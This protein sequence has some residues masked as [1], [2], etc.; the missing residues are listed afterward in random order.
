M[1]NSSIDYILL[2]RVLL[3]GRYFR[4]RR[5]DIDCKILHVFWIFVFLL[6]TEGIFRRWLLPQYSNLFLVIRDPFVIY[7]V[8]LGVKNNYLGNNIPII[9]IVLS[10]ISFLLTL[11]VGHGNFL[12]ALYGVRINL[13]YIPFVYVCSCALRKKDIIK[14]GFFMT[15]LICPMVILSVVQF[16][17]SQS[18]FVNIGVGGDEGGAG[19][20]GA[21]GYY[22]PPGIFTFI[23]GLTD[24]YALAFPFLLYFILNRKEA[25]K[26]II[27][28]A[29]LI[30]TF[31]AYVVSLF[32]SISRTHMTTSITVMIMSA[33]VVFKGKNA[34]VKIVLI[35]IFGIVVFNLLLLN[36][37]F[38]LFVKVFFSRFDSANEIEG[39]FSQS[40]YTRTFGWL[41]RAI[42]K[43][44]IIG[45]GE[46][47]FTN[48]GMKTLYGGA[49]NYSGQI[50]V[51]E[52][53]TEMEWGRL[54]CEDGILLGLSF[55]ILRFIMA[56]QIFLYAIK[57]LI[58]NKMTLLWFLMP[59][60]CVS[61]VN[62]QLKASYNLG[63]M[64][65]EAI[66]CMV[67]IRSLNRSYEKSFFV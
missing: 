31:V 35:I 6:M 23:S 58:T 51:V 57:S 30:L 64:V 16:F 54:I 66:S 1:N 34:F 53:A 4:L 65:L 11:F 19:F 60:A 20:G 9:F 50:K 21:E 44:G 38:E 63:F 46:G 45:Y 10:I 32:V 49:L 24:Y 5:N 56:L 18:S 7:V 39:S 62:Y 13:F 17:S 8:L 25:Q 67:L 2:G 37:Q 28:K 14:L 61:I 48:F 42:D 59:M 12:V 26:Q 22:R 43:V 29:Y 52:D 40:L 27:P 36:E 47:H 41:F 55:I 15:I 3:L 33:F